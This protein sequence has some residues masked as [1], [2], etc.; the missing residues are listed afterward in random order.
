MY[1]G[2]QSSAVDCEDDNSA[3]IESD[4]DPVS[5][6]IVTCYK[7]GRWDSQD[8]CL[9]ALYPSVVDVQELRTIQFSTRLLDGGSF[10]PVYT[11]ICCEIGA[12]RGEAQARHESRGFDVSIPS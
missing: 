6:D 5:F 1:S 4:S 2:E 8:R 9:A 12:V 3:I 11:T 7:E 10:D